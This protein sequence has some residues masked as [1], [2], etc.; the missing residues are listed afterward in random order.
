ME[1]NRH[2]GFPV[3]SIVKNLPAS[4]GD[5][6]LIPGSGRGHAN[7]LQQFCL[8]NPMDKGAWWA[9]VQEVAKS[10]T[11]LSNPHFQAVSCIF[12]YAYI[13]RGI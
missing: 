13:N 10:Q 5:M 2:A 4:A 6:G 1:L 8:E 12:V 3:G 7:P 9:T 11:R